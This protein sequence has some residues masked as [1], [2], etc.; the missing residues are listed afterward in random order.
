MPKLS[1]YLSD[2]VYEAVRRYE[3]PVS[4]VAQEALRAEVVRRA[5]GEWN[6]RALRRPIR[7][8]PIDTSVVIDEVRGEFGA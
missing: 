7:T 3:I 2:A 8:A 6:A 4:S 5:N 1:V